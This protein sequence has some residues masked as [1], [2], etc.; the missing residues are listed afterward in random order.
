MKRLFETE[1]KEIKN[2]LKNSEFYQF[3]EVIHNVE[4]DFEYELDILQLSPDGNF[5]TVSKS[6]QYEYGFTHLFDNVEVTDGYFSD[7]P[8]DAEVSITPLGTHCGSLKFTFGWVHNSNTKQED[9]E[10][11]VM[12]QR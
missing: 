12:P 3:V 9:I 7:L 8:D 10:D 5:W 2:I 11:A 6:Q 1:L 4:S